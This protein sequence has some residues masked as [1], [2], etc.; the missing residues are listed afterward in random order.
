MLGVWEGKEMFMEYTKY[1][2]TLTCKKPW[3]D[4]I[5]VF[6]PFFFS[7]WYDKGQLRQS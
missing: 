5:C 2:N 4:W 7:L 6:L 3:L 1:I